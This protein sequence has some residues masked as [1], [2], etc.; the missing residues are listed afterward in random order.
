MDLYQRS[1]L[2]SYLASVDVESVK[3]AY[4]RYRGHFLHPEKQKN[5][6]L[7]KEEQY[8]EGFLRE[9]FV[10]VL[11][12]TINPTIG[13]NLVTEQ[14]NITD[15]K[16]ADAAILVD[17]IIRG[18]VELKGTNTIDL[19]RVQDQAFRYYN[20]HPDAIYIITSNFEKLRFYIQKTNEYE[21]FNLFT[22]NLEDFT[23]LY[24]CISYD[25]ISRGLPLKIKNESVIK[26]QDITKSL[27]KDYSRFKQDLFHDLCAQNR[28]MDKLVLFKASQKLIDRFLFVFF[29]EDNNGLLPANSIAEIIKHWNKLREMDE[30]RPLYDIFKKYFEYINVG[31]P[32]SSDRQEIFAYNGGLFSED[33]L[34]DS[35]HIS[36]TVLYTH[37]QKL[38]G[39]DFI[40]EVDVNILGH[41]FEH[42]LNELEELQ[43]QLEGQTIDKTKTKRKK[44]GV[45]YTPRYITEYIVENTIGK[46]CSDKIESLSLVEAE[47]VLASSPTKRKTLHEKLQHYKTFLLSLTIC[48]PA[49]GSGAFLNQAFLF[50]QKQ[51]QYI[52]DLESKLFDTPLALTDVSAD[53]LEHNLYGVDINEESVEIARLSLWLRS[54]RRGRKLNNLSSN[55]KCGNSLIDVPELAGDKAFKWEEE[56]PQVFNK[57]GFDVIIGNPPYGAKLS[58]LHQKFLNEKYISGASET[59]IAFIK[60]SYDYLIN[61]TG[62]LSFIIPKSLFMLQIMVP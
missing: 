9:L 43:A 16:K 11:G 32:S 14:Q 62:V 40:S 61:K 49:C 4:E 30:Y 12:Y 20:N 50:L 18:V 47:F 58:K 28:S 55:I 53:I 24:L 33:T 19:Q 38:S 3:S 25:S 41:I 21:E 42:S 35:I 26:E 15:Q 13:Y 22:L 7:S 27:Y 45:F 59:T 10:D 6:R 46:L 36:D 57:G 52:A 48:D 37:A 23:Y 54:A 2:K 60:L 31:R 56:F 44:D 8:Q 1:V 5:I 39:Y 51:H 29:C 17:G 34:L